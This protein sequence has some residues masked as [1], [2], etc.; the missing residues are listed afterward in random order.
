MRPAGGSCAGCPPRGWREAYEARPDPL[1][2]LSREEAERLSSEGRFIIAVDAER[3]A[4]AFQSRVR[5][6]V[7]AGPPRLLLECGPSPSDLLD[8]VRDKILPLFGVPSFERYCED[9]AGGPAARARARVA[10][11]SIVCD[12]MLKH[13]GDAHAGRQLGVM[14]IPTVLRSVIAATCMLRDCVG[15]PQRPEVETPGR[16]ARDE[17]CSAVH[18]FYRKRAMLQPLCFCVF[19]YWLVKER[20]LQIAD[21]VRGGE[22]GDDEALRRVRE[23][24]E[25]GALASVP[26][27]PP[28]PPGPGDESDG[29]DGDG[30]PESLLKTSM[31]FARRMASLNAAVQLPPPLAEIVQL[32]GAADSR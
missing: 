24:I 27:L 30:L 5:H 18:F 6:L 21:A 16:I 13:L 15:G 17:L 9:D 1:A 20:C 25:S 26:P 22:F 3:L 4:P 7:P 28:R 31:Q 11:A 8:A 10:G 12:A 19:E 14:Q 2:G 32:L 29:E 23:A